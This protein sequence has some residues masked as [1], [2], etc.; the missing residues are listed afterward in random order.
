MKRT[1]AIIVSMF[2]VASLLTCWSRKARAQ[3]NPAQTDSPPATIAEISTDYIIVK[4]KD[5]SA[6]SYPGGIN[7]IGRTKPLK[8]KFDPTSGPARAYLRSLDKAH[9]NYRAWLARNAGAARAVRDYKVAFNGVAIELNGVPAEKAASGPGVATWSYSVIYHPSMNVSTKLIGADILWGANRV[10]AGRGFAVG[11]IDTGIQDGHPFFACKGQNGIPAIHHHGPYFSGDTPAGPNNPFPVIVNPHGTHVA[12]TI[13]GC[14]SDLSTIDPASPIVGLIS[15]M[16]PAVTLHD[17]NVFPGIGAAF[18]NPKSP[19]GAF[20]HDIA[21]AI[22]DAVL[23]PVDVINMSLGGTVQGPND[24]LAEMADAAVDAGVVVAVAAGNSGPGDATVESPGTAR[25]VITVGGSSNPHFVGIPVTVGATTYGAAL[26]EFANFSHVTAPYSVTSPANGCAPFTADL[27]GQ[28]ALVDRGVCTFGTKVLDAQNAAAIGV[29]IVNNRG[30]DPIPM[31]LDT[32]LPT[33]TIPAA[34]LS[35]ADGNAIKPSGTATVDGTPQE[36]VSS[37][38]D[39]LAD[40]SSRGP[41]PFTF[42]IKPDVTAPGVNVYS[43]VFSFGP[44]G[45]NDI[46]YSFE[47]FDG[48]SMATPH[49][50]GSAILLLAAH[51]D[52][53]P[54]DVRSAIVNNA[55]RVVTDT[56]TASVDPGVL[57]RGGGR[58][59]LPAAVATPLTI[60]PASA[61]FGK[62]I[63]NRKVTSAMDLQVRNVSGT[64]QTCSVSVTGPTIVTATP[65]SFTLNDGQVAT[66]HVS[67]IAG[68]SSQT[69]SA[70]YDGDVVITTGT[71]QLLVPWLVR[72]DRAGK[73]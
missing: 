35:Q 38:A 3:V 5:P 11:V 13:G 16:A 56:L 14:V 30:G 21:Q 54:A 59:A 57:A 64:A 6:A 39:I 60:S 52:W 32:S 41:A 51:P 45:F 42:I 7:G 66:V 49:A 19:G 70:D 61:S 23:T 68:S 26:G 25:N 36:F 29:L 55:A 12:G 8:G 50:A 9:G 22:E 17:F 72:I 31:A 48:T 24:F 20:S 44:G 28:I 71:T 43:S 27:T 2:V 62:F 65:G 34:M 69:D 1:T 53:S 33:P 15:G 46:Q 67:L 63:G 73:P 10:D 58:I 18:K 40:F 37:N 47:M 4:F